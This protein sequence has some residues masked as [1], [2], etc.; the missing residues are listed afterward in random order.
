MLTN[1][2]IA[3][4]LR[5][6]KEGP[7]RTL[8][9]HWLRHSLQENPPPTWANSREFGSY[10]GKLPMGW[11]GCNEMTWP[12]R[13]CRWME[14]RKG[15]NKIYGR[16]Y[17]YH[18]PRYR[19]RGDEL[20]G[21]CEESGHISTRVCSHFILKLLWRITFSDHQYCSSHWREKLIHVERNVKLEVPKLLKLGFDDYRDDSRICSSLKVRERGAGVEDHA[22]LTRGIKVEAPRGDGHGLPIH[23]NP[24][25]AKVVEC[26][27]HGVGEGGSV[28]DASGC[29][30]VANNQRARLGAPQGDQAVREFLAGHR[31]RLRDERQRS[32]T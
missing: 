11:P 20:K 10:I 24:F 29:G 15:C 18:H 23:I 3:E 5:K 16:S 14:K 13:D 7:W 4:L 9:W 19:Y 12:L 6:I 25:D 31:S 22:T 8:D 1:F 17:I 21:P 32:L 26:R 2:E 27:V 30:C 28:G